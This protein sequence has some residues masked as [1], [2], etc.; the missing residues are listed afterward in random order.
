M[1]TAVLEYDASALIYL[2]RPGVILSDTT[3]SLWTQEIVPAV[4][5][6]ITEP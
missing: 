1:T 2:D 3:V 5:A 6:A 4:R